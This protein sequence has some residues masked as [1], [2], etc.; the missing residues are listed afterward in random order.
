MHLARKIRTTVKRTSL[1]TVII[2]LRPEEHFQY[3]ELKKTPESW[4]Y[5]QERQVGCLFENVLYMH[6]S[7]KGRSMRIDNFIYCNFQSAYLANY[8]TQYHAGW[9]K[10]FKGL[11]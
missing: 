8:V 2:P 7:R 4:L 6:P 11:R 5:H 10:V 1:Y 9:K 3:F